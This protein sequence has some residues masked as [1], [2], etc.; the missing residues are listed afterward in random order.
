MG[1]QTTDKPPATTAKALQRATAR[2]GTH[3]EAMA[4]HFVARTEVRLFH[5]LVHVQSAPRRHQGDPAGGLLDRRQVRLE[6]VFE[7]VVDA[8]AHLGSVLVLVL[9]LHG[10]G[11]TLQRMMLKLVG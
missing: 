6:N 3:H 8:A 11:V 1:M 9:D 10:E 7:L 5:R 2:V 4:Q